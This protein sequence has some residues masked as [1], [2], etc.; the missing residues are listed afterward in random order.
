[1]GWVRKGLWQ[2]TSY[3]LLEK[4]HASMMECQCLK[5]I[6][7]KQTW[8]W[9]FDFF[10]NFNNWIIIVCISNTHTIACR[11]CQ[12]YLKHL[13]KKATWKYEQKSN[14]QEFEANTIFDRHVF[15]RYLTSYNT[16]F[17][18]FQLHVQIN[19]VFYTLK[20]CKIM[21][22]ALWTTMASRIIRLMDFSSTTC[23]Q[24]MGGN[25]KKRRTLYV[26][27][28]YQNIN[29]TAKTLFS[30]TIGIRIYLVQFICSDWI[31]K[32]TNVQCLF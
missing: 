5:Q 4:P 18:I 15:P 30:D 31:L 3:P 23:E 28:I 26:V 27:H 11:M 20:K 24:L 8:M 6:H 14:P 7:R 9:C 2:S 19:Y 29:N 16:N 12:Y 22:H 13:L 32:R 17:K 25:L 1:M 10:N 21:K